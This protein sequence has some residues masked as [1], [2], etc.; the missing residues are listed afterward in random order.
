MEFF[1]ELTADQK[2]TLFVA[3]A[4]AL[5]GGLI[6]T[7]ASW[8]TT[9]QSIVANETTRQLEK[10]EKEAF[11]AHQGLI[12]INQYANAAYSLKKMIDD[13]FDAANEAGHGDWLPVQKVRGTPKYDESFESFLSEEMVFLLKTKDSQMLGDMIVFEKRVV[14]SLNNF[15]TYSEER[16]E[17]SK[18]LQKG[19]IGSSQEGIPSLSAELEGEFAMIADAEAAFLTELLGGI[20]EMLDRDTKDGFSLLHRYNRAAKDEYGDLFPTLEYE[21][22]QC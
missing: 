22:S 19:V 7:A 21:A 16:I 10:R 5:L 2:L 8:L 13:Q 6:S 15:H 17:W 9:R 4:S 3:F 11:Y 1:Q 14:A 20:M 18:K 12:K